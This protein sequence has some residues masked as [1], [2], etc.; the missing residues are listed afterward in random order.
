MPG[1]RILILY[2]HGVKRVGIV[3]QGEILDAALV[4]LVIS[5]LLTVG[6]PLEAIGQAELLVIVPVRCP[7]DNVVARI[8]SELLR[9]A[10][11]DLFDIEV[12]LR[13][14][15]LHGTHISEIGCPRSIRRELSKHQPR[16]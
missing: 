4:E 12:S 11:L 1:L 15:A 14:G 8:G 2:D 7:I 9:R 16:D 6:T 13:I 3:D 5:D 10:C